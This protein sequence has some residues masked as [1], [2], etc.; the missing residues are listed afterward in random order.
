MV[1]NF[2]SEE[3][4]EGNA[5]ESGDYECDA[6]ASER[7]WN[8]IV[9]QAFANGGQ[10]GDGEKPAYARSGAVDGGC[11]GIGEFA[12]LHDEHGAKNSAVHG[13][14]WQEDSQR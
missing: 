2:D 9:G 6:Y 14:Q 8:L 5:H 3:A 13:Y 10:A 7:G 4:H 1:L 12:L 11:L